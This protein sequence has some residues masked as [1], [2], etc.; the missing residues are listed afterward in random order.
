[1]PGVR[2]RG[3]TA[4]R[5]GRAPTSLYAFSSSWPS[6]PEDDGNSGLLPGPGSRSRR[7]AFPIGA[8]EDASGMMNRDHAPP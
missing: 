1:M 4:Q 7:C 2:L 6:L 3:R 5:T 8:P